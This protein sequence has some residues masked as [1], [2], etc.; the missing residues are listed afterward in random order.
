ML[1]VSSIEAEK[2]SVRISFRP[3]F[4]EVLLPIVSMLFQHSV[5]VQRVPAHCE[6]PDAKPHKATVLAQVLIFGI[7]HSAVHR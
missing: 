7:V 3:D 1:S 5:P 2:P 6:G 4:S